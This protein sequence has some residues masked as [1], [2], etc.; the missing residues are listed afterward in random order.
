MVGS[1]LG[2]R[3][4][5]AWC[6]VATSVVLQGLASAQAVGADPARRA[7]IHP[8]LVKLSPREGCRFG[9]VLAP[10]R[11][12]R[13][14][15]AEDVKWSVNDVP[16][17]TR[18]LGTIDKKGRYRA[19]ASP[20]TPHEVHICAEVDGAANRYLWATVLI[21]EPEP[22][23]TLLERWSEPADGSAN[24][25]EPQAIAM[26]HDGNL[27]ITDIGSGR[28]LRYSKSGQLLGEIGLGGGN[29]PGRFD[30]PRDVA[31]D[32]DGNVFVCDLRTGPPRIQVFGPDGTY[33][34]S[35]AQKG[36]APGQ[37]LQTHGAAFDRDSRFL[38]T[39]TDNMRVNV[40]TH[41]GDLIEAWER[42]GLNPGELNAPYGL[43]LDRNGDVFVPGYYGPCQKFSRAGVF[44][45]AFARPRPPEGPVF[46]HN[47]TGDRWG[48]VYLA[49]RTARYTKTSILRDEGAEVLLMKYNNHG[50]LVATFELSTNELGENGMIVDDTDRLYVLF[51]REEEVGVEVYGER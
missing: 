42:S 30:N 26:D 41:S 51:R 18:K 37:V 44:L 33:L 40:F 17:G 15:E 4:A 36:T 48:N 12:S 8:T 31:V 20:P 11:M 27:V 19:P 43:V 35:F 1:S 13:A 39:D 38:V 21:G 45:F 14:V 29:A 47:A 10:G 24:L 23:Y 28:V 25:K 46:F 49:A 9:I 50:D 22:A 16:G 7:S 5:L 32:E 3:S 6:V 34:R 2:K